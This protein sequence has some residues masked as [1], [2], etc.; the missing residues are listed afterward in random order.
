MIRCLQNEKLIYKKPTT[1][2]EVGPRQNSKY[3]EEETEQLLLKV[4][5]YLLF[6]LY[7]QLLTFTLQHT[8]QMQ[9]RPTNSK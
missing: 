2:S 4:F 8:G 6:G 7:F 9:P 3:T 5:I 1:T